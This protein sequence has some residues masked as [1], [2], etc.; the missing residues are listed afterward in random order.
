LIH[1]LAIGVAMAW[2][3]PAAWLWQ[4]AP[5]PHAYGHGLLFIY[6]MWVFVTL[7]L[8]VP[9]RWFEGVK[10]RHRWWWLRYL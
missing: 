10:R 9:C 4:R 3:Q 6:A 1:L 2:G 8:Y 5:R 7:V